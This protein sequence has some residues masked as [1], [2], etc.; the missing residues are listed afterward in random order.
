MRQSPASS[1]YSI[2]S[3]R[4]I[5]TIFKQL[6]A[7]SVNEKMKTDNLLEL[8][9]P[10]SSLSKFKSLTPGKEAAAV[11]ANVNRY[12]NLTSWFKLNRKSEETYIIVK[13]LICSFSTRR[14]RSG[15]LV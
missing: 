10:F 4:T 5:G 7:G 2:I 15:F 11:V 1:V 14:Y 13:L 6:S 3:T 12:Y 8:S 9:F